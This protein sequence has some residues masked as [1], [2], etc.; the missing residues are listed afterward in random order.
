MTTRS[1]LQLLFGAAALSFTGMA[2]AQV[3][4][5]I[6]TTTP[7]GGIVNENVHY[8]AK[9][10]VYLTGGPGPNAPP[11]A[12]GLPFGEYYFQITDP[13]GKKLLS[14]D[15]VRNRCVVVGNPA[16]PTGE[17]GFITD[18][19]CNPANG[20]GTHDLNPKVG[21]AHEFVVQMIP[22]D[23][24][25]NNGGVYKA[26]MTPVGAFVGDIN[27]VDNP[28]QGGGCFHG[29]IESTSKTDNFK[30]R[31]VQTFCITAWKFIEDKK[32]GTAAQAG[33]PILFAGNVEHTG[34]D[35]S[36]SICELTPG[37]YSI[38]ELLPND[39]IVVGTQINRDVVSPPVTSVT[40]T[41]GKGTPSE[42][43][44]NVIWT[45]RNV[46]EQPCEKGCYYK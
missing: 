16:D 14:T 41:V 37:T 13:S 38:S 42:R 1:T 34:E 24:T 7:D 27:A 15:P 36:V 30:V 45:N 46:F 29:F 11:E 19:R 44:P 10:D 21:T 17:R 5:A 28:C 31:D 40:V 35:G 2:S 32:T 39:F 3:A 4:G 26:W 22:F 9:E 43:N 23:D 8:T 12:A 6:H 25:P 18:Q 33:W 20:P